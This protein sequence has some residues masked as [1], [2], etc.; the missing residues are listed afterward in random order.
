M[1]K[2]LFV[3]LCACG[4]TSFAQDGFF[5]QPEIGIGAA[6]AHVRSPSYGYNTYNSSEPKSFTTY[7]GQI[8]VGYQHNNWSINTGVGLLKSGYKWNYLGGDFVTTYVT[9]SHIDYHISVPLTV[10]YQVNISKL[11]FITPAVGGAVSYNYAERYTYGEGVYRNQPQQVTS[12]LLQGSELAKQ[13][14]TTSVWGILQVRAGY[15]LNDRLS[16]VAGPEGQFMTGSILKDNNNYQ[17]NY[18]YT[19]N[20]GA[21]WHLGKGAAKGTSRLPQ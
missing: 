21:I 5:L 18:A 14:H 7:T 8:G 3:A 9:E 10:A 4:F 11:F 15:K 17:K 12:R 20:A 16:I 19:F 2:V 1:K 13:D 6:N